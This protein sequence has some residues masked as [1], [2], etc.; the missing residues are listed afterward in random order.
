MTHITQWLR[1]H[2]NIMTPDLVDVRQSATQPAYYVELSRGDFMGRE[3]WG[4][5]LW[6][7]TDKERQPYTNQCPEVRADEELNQCF[8]SRDE[9]EGH[10]RYVLGRVAL[11]PR[12]VAR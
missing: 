1:Q 6:R 4:V 7:E 5:T 9:A 3:L 10:V 12:E 8:E 2:K 11:L